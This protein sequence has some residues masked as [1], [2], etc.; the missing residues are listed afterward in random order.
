ME[1]DGCLDLDTIE[2]VGVFVHQQGL[3]RWRP[4]FKQRTRWIQGHYQCWR[5]IPRL[6]RAKGTP[7]I[8]R[9]D[10]SLYLLLVLTVVAVFFTG[11]L[12]LAVLVA[13]VPVTDHSLEFLHNEFALRLASFVLCTGPLLT[14]LGVYQ[15]LSPRRLRVWELPA[16]CLMFTLYSYLVWVVATVRAWSRLIRRKGGWTKTPR[17][18]GATVGIAATAEAA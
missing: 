11:V 6:L 3:D 15:K 12:S 13:D 2:K 5:Y 18:A 4:L 8:G 16:Y 10:L 1:A 17:V 7:L 14:T 9:I